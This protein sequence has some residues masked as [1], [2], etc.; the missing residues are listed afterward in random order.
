METEENSRIETQT[1]SFSTPVTY[2]SRHLHPCLISKVRVVARVRPFLP[3]EI[4]SKNENPISCVS[5]LNP[6]SQTSGDEVTVLLKDQESRL[7]NFP[8]ICSQDCLFFIF[9]FLVGEENLKVKVFR[10]DG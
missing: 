9:I 6:E 1:R 8:F 3:R 5:L 4:S 7:Y 10:V 2:S